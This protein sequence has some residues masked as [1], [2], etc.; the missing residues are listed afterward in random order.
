MLKSRPQHE[1]VELWLNSKCTFRAGRDKGEE[2]RFLRTWR[3][4]G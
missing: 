1:A 4:V 3:S 2:E